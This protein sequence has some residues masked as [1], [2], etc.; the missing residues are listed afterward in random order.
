M[1]E[2]VGRVQSDDEW[3][4][5]ALSTTWASVGHLNSCF[6]SWPGTMNCSEG[7]PHV[8]ENCWSTSGS[9]WPPELNKQC[10]QPVLVPVLCCP[11]NL[12]S[13]LP[14]YITRRNQWQATWL[15]LT[16]CAPGSQC[17]DRTS[18]II[19][20]CPISPHGPRLHFILLPRKLKIKYKNI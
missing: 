4:P 14:A 20:L 8:G 9:W 5:V 19:W 1:Q 15:Q 13:A 16:D 12:F 18:L 7:I 6:C 11:W 3:C 17:S 2:M 10:M